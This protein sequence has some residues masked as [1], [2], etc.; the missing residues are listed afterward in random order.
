METKE[1]EEE[2]WAEIEH[3]IITI[4]TMLNV[5]F[6]KLKLLSWALQAMGTLMQV[7]Y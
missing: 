4:L 1:E 3:H 2:K 6:Q 7:R 5:S